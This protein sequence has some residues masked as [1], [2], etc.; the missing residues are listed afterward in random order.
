MRIFVTPLYIRDASATAALRAT[1][2]LRWA[3]LTSQAARIAAVT[4][5]RDALVW[6]SLRARSDEIDHVDRYLIPLM[7]LAG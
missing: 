1:R 5:F 7:L 2:Q 6:R 4:R 3:T